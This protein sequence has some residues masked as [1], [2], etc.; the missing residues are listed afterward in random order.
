MQEQQNMV[1]TA[2]NAAQKPFIELAPNGDP[3]IFTPGANGQWDCDRAS[4]LRTT[5]ERKRGKIWFQDADSLIKFIQKHREEGTEIYID[6]NFSNGDIGVLAVINGDTVAAA[7]WRDFIG[8]YNAQKTHAAKEWLG[9]DKQ[10]TNQAK[11]AHFLT[12]NARDIVAQ[13]PENPEA[14]YPSAAE[15]LDFAL[16]LEYTEK[17]T[18]KQGYREQDGR[19]NF[20]FE[21]EDSGK[22]TQQLKMFEKFGIA[23]T[24]FLNGDSYFVEALLKFRIDKNNGQLLLWFELQ[25]IHAVMERAARDVAALLQAQF[26]DIPIYYGKP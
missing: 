15:V 11:F 22:T 21:S 8:I 12:G 26:S 18:F 25:Q 5:P 19:I 7:G 3:L 6:A 24:P 16:N 10:A 2:L 13:S 14:K 23:F 4:Q 1:Q 9:M 17:T 20:T